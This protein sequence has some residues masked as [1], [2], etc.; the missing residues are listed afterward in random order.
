MADFPFKDPERERFEG[1]TLVVR[2]G[3]SRY[4]ADET[5]PIFGRFF[6]R[7]EV[8]TV[9]GAGHWVVSEAFEETTKAVVDWVR[10]VVDGEGE[11][12]GE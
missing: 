4:V 5:L 12:E 3:T 8:V 10:R 6:P 2:G 9:E 11:G 7:F 1:P